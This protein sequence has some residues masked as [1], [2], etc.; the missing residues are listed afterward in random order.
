VRNGYALEA[1][2]E[3]GSGGQTA[4]PPA[5][6]LAALP[7]KS[8]VH[9]PRAS[10]SLQTVDQDESMPAFSSSLDTVPVRF[11][12]LTGFKQRATSPV[13]EDWRPQG[14]VPLATG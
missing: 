11:Q 3:P 12:R 9:T 10:A 5:T 6:G 2:A 13:L 8:S 1:D 4:S 14:V 7:R